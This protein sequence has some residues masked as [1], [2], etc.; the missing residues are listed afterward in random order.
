MAD[1]STPSLQEMTAGIVCGYVEKHRV[2][3]DDLPALIASIYASL[4][5]IDLP[6][7]PEAEAPKKLTPA[8]IRKSITPDALISFVDGKA[9][10]TL[11]RHLAGNGLTP[12]QYRERFGLGRDYPMTAASYSAMRSAM[13]KSIGLGAKVTRP[14]GAKGAKA[15]ANVTKA[16]A[17][18]KATPKAPAAKAE[19]WKVQ[20][21]KATRPKGA[22]DPAKDDYT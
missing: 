16:P 1:R 12:S 21:A 19:G 17:A 8:M 20:K 18:V 3:P 15:P 7:E 4:S 22:I 5:G 10:K 13:A 9:Y 2:A 6:A 11:K 14:T